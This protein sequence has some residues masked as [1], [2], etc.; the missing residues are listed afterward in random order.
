MSNK[1]CPILAGLEPMRRELYEP[2][3]NEAPA[4]TSTKKG[5]QKRIEC[6]REQCEW[7][8]NGC[9]AHKGE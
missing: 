9:P 2:E 1:W 4:L 8:N 5:I 6:A 7:Y 3:L